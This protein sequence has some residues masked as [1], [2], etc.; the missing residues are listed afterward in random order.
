VKTP[1]HRLT[2]VTHL[3]LNR[4]NPA[5]AAGSHDPFL[6]WYLFMAFP[7]EVSGLLSIARPYG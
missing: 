1:L 7:H 5:S 3:L 2:P 4:S 6:S